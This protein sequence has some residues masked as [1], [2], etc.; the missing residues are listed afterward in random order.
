MA[1]HV[2]KCI[3]QKCKYY[4]YFVTGKRILCS[5]KDIDKTFFFKCHLIM[6]GRKIRLE[7][8]DKKPWNISLNLLC[9]YLLISS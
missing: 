3:V 7:M 8:K 6:Y 4:C 9:I 1:H 5:L 2:E